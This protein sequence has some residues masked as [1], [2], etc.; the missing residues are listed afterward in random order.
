MIELMLTIDP[1][2][3][4][5]ICSA[6]SREPARRDEPIVSAARRGSLDP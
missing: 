1:P 5:T 3:D 4:F 2:P 6:C